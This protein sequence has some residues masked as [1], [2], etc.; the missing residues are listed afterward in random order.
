[1]C[2]RRVEPKAK[3]SSPAGPCRTRALWR[4]WLPGDPSSSCQWRPARMTARWVSEE[5]GHQAAPPNRLRVAGHISPRPQQSTRPHRPVARSKGATR[6]H[7]AQ[8]TIRPGEMR[9]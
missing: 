7:T 2:Q 6:S 4:G 1:M 8:H 5:T 9:N 3:D